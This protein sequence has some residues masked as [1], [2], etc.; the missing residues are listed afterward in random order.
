MKQHYTITIPKLQ[1]TQD[2]IYHQ[3]LKPLETNA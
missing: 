1:A 3:A 2:Y